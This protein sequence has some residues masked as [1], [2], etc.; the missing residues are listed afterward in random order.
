MEICF[1]ISSLSGGGA[2]R[3]M[4]LLANW[5]SQYYEVGIITMDKAE[6]FYKLKKEVSIYHLDLV[7]DSGNPFSA[8]F[9]NLNRV[10][11]LKTKIKTLAPRVVI[12]FITEMNVLTLLATKS[13][14]TKVIVSER[15]DPNRKSLSSLWRLLRDLNY[16][17]A[18]AIVSQTKK[19]EHFISKKYKATKSVILS[20]PLQMPIP[21]GEKKETLLFVGRFDID[22]GFDMIPSILKDLKL[23]DWQVEIAGSG[24]LM[25]QVQLE[26]NRNGLSSKVSFLGQY[27]HV[28]ELYDNASIFA[29]PS[30]LEGYPNALIE[31]MHFGCA[32]VSFDCN[33]GPAEIIIEGVNGLLVEPENTEGMSKAIQQLID[34][35]NLRKRLAN[36]GQNITKNLSLDRVGSQWQKLMTEL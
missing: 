7:S 6:S 26:I 4:T 16:S 13:L 3:V 12:S 35:A 11:A 5:L 9:K 15:S 28:D 33:N 21:E 30:R 27:K 32:C 25:S 31:A 24:N 2:A 19:A 14:D 23:G 18:D 20:N 10:N 36:E 17:N 8:L 22:K 29:L 1:V 34:D